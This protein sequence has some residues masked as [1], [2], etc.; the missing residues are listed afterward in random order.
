MKSHSIKVLYTIICE[1]SMCSAVVGA[2]KRL[3][4]CGGTSKEARE[5][6]FGHRSLSIGS[7]AE[8][9]QSTG[10]PASVGVRRP[11]AVV[12]GERAANKAAEFL[13]VVY[14]LRGSLW[15]LRPQTWSL[16]G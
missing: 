2:Y 15:C 12:V 4:P 11:A 7:E 14:E 10:R 1:G 9:V 5:E 13:V 3:A 8:W 16:C 6:R